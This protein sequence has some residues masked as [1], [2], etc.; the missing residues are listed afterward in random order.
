MITHSLSSKI[1]P[2]THFW[3][4]AS[5]P[6]CLELI[7][8][9]YDDCLADHGSCSDSDSPTVPTRLIAIEGGEVDWKARLI[10]RPKPSVQYA[11]LSHRW[12][13]DVLKSA[14]TY[15]DSM[16]KDIPRSSL[17]RTFQDAVA[18]YRYLRIYY[19]WIDS[20]CIVQQCARDWEFESARMADTYQNAYLVLAASAT[21][22]GI[23]VTRANISFQTC[24]FQDVGR[25]VEVH[26]RR[27]I[28]HDEYH[29]TVHDRQDLL[30]LRGGRCK[31][32]CLRVDFSHLPHP[33]SNGSVCRFWNA[34]AAFAI[35]IGS[36]LHLT[37]ST[38]CSVQMIE[39]LTTVGSNLS[40]SSPSE[41]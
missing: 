33:K 32:A 10:E 7:K 35:K 24:I 23:L 41:N 30:S 1:S 6:V 9:W 14:S 16:L 19:L 27:R 13:S 3:T 26:V 39:P 2:K 20:L 29:P 4:N 31:S 21:T 37:I 28:S 25:P 15:L 18:F 40:V 8:G 22:D 34:S 38:I 5:S 12:N 36:T 17:W 11:A